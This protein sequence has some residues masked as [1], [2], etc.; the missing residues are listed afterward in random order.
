[1]HAPVDGLQAPVASVQPLDGG[2]S[3]V[4]GAPLTQ[5]PAWQEARPLQRLPS[6]QSVPLGS[7]VWVTAPV[8]ELQASAVQGFE[9]SGSTGVPAMQV[10]V[11]LHWSPVVQ[12]SPSLHDVPAGLRG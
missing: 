5:A 11:A 12:P 3:Q 2:E 1:V 10:P 7:D 6:S 9:S 4:T 8:D